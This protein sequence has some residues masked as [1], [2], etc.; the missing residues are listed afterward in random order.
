MDV[1]ECLEIHYAQEVAGNQR[2]G[3]VVATHVSCCA[4]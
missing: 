3:H 4:V 2:R 1:L